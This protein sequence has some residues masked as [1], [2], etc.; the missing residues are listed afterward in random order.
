MYREVKE[1]A[2]FLRIGHN[3]GLK[4]SGNWC[5]DEPELDHREG[6]PPASEK[7][8]PMPDQHRHLVLNTQGPD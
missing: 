2:G 6:I 7:F 3:R 4:K 1:A 8:S 5:P